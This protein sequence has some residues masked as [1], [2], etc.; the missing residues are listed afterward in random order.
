MKVSVLASTLLPQDLPASVQGTAFDVYHALEEGMSADRLAH[1]AGRSCYQA[2]EM[3]N[4]KTAN[5][6]GYLDNILNQGHY[7]VLEPSVV[8][9]YIERVSRSLLAELT[10][11]RH[12]S[13]S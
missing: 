3:P 4:N 7:S 13:F 10:R 2:W 8:S 9:F 6:E 5:D 12:L 1:F 11:H